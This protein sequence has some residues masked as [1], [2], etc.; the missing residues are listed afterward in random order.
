MLT[1]DFNMCIC[2]FHVFV[3]LDNEGSDILAELAIYGYDERKT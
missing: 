2:D 1:F 3:I